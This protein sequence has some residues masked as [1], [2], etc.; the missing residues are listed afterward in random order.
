MLSFEGLMLM[1]L[2]RWDGSWAEEEEEEEEVGLRFSL[3]GK[4]SSSVDLEFVGRTRK[5]CWIH[6]HFL[7]R[8]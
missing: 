4:S 2:M 1:K 6:L 5:G 3:R 7:E 8:S